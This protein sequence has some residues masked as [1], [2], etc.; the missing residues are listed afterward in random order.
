MQAQDAPA[1]WWAALTVWAVVNAVCVL[2]GVGYVSRIRTR[3]MTL[4]RRLGVVMIALAAPAAAALVAFA[5]TGAGW[6]WWLGPAVYLAFVALMGVVDYVAP[7]E[8]RS[9]PRYA[10]LVPYLALF[11][12]AIVLMGL[13]MFS[14]DRALWLVT[15]ASAAFLVVAMALALRKGVG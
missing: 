5:R 3:S 11:F 4:N 14:V 6:E 7:R 2:Q 12:G 13:P 10:V 15:V 1:P 9:P 8:F